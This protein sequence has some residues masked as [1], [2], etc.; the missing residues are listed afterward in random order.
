MHK[1]NIL[2]TFLMEDDHEAFTRSLF[3]YTPKHPKSIIK[4]KEI[5]LDVFFPHAPEK[6]E[7]IFERFFNMIAKWIDQLIG[8]MQYA[9][10]NMCGLKL[11]VPTKINNFI[12]NPVLYSYLKYL[13]DTRKG[14]P[15]IFDI[16]DFDTF[17]IFVNNK[18]QKELG[19]KNA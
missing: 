16:A 6:G 19:Y 5:F 11:T 17:N 7:Q 8:R 14:V 10:K 18:M 15:R 2:D 3:K 4:F 9:N 13:K 12:R 1:W